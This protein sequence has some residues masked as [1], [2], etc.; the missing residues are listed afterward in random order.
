M[1]CTQKLPVIK[2]AAS[3]IDAKEPLPDEW[4]RTLLELKG[5]I[6]AGERRMANLSE[7][8]ENNLIDK[9]GY[10]KLCEDFTVMNAAMAKRMS[11]AEAGLAG[12][13]KRLDTIC[14]HQDKL[15]ET[16][17]THHIKATDYNE[18]C[19]LR[20]RVNALAAWA[21]GPGGEK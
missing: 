19:T 17:D 9:V 13:T 3:G 4:L 2:S 11:A 6:Q 15:A 21:K 16:V 20:D 18:F 12:I 1:N 7:R 10:R 8:V 14:K 5:E